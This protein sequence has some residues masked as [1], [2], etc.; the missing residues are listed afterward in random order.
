MYLRFIDALKYRSSSEHTCSNQNS[1]LYLNTLDHNSLFVR[2]NSAFR[3]LG[4][5]LKEIMRTTL[6]FR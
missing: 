2:L 1:V 3:F 6:V 4:H 5:I